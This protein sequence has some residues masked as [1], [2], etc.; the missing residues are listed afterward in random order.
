MVIT[1][2][3]GEVLGEH[4]IIGHGGQLYEPN[5]RV[6]FLAVGPDM[7]ALP[8]ELN[9]MEAHPV[10]LHGTLGG[11]P[12]HSSAF[13]MR[14]LDE[15]PQDDVALGQWQGSQKWVWQ[16]GEVVRYDLD[17]DPGELAP[18]PDPDVA[19]FGEGPARA[20]GSFVDT[21]LDLD[22]ATLEMLQAA[23]YLDP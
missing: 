20:L 4:G 19:R 7:P 11:F 2:D 18:I 17:A 9:A 14:Y 6:V 1:S 15:Q 16:A 21:D 12:T 13:P 8:D 22:P 3:H 10:L 23:G 5:N